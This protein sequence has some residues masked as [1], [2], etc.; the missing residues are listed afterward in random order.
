MNTNPAMK[1]K[2][3][4]EE[5]PG[6]GSPAPEGVGVKVPALRV[7]VGVRVDVGVR[8]G[9][10]VFVG[11]GI[12]EILGVGVTVSILVGVGD[13]T[14][15]VGVG[16]RVTLRVGVGLCFFVGVG[17]WAEGVA[18]NPGDSFS[19]AKTTVKVRR[20]VFLPKEILRV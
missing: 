11:I 7:G 12:C 17:V 5:F 6:T 13:V 14:L 1:I 15:R 4:G 10:G 3:V 18:V 9:V 19:A 2:N 16:V 8:V 20:M